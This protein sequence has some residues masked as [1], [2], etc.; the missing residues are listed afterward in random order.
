MPSSLGSPGSVPTLREYDAFI[1]H[2]FE[3]KAELVRPLADRLR[4]YGA[5]IWYDEFELRP[6]DSLVAKIDRGLA[7]SNHGILIISPAFLCKPWPEY[8]R[9]GL[10]ARDIGSGGQILV[11]VWHNVDA[12]RV[13]SFSPTLAQRFALITNTMHVD[14]LA[15]RLLEVVRPDLSEG[16]RRRALFDELVANAT[17][18]WT[19]LGKVQRP[20]EPVHGSLPS[21]LLRRIRLIQ[22]ALYEVL[23][24]SFDET[25]ESFKRDLHPE[26]E[27][28]FWESIAGTYLT[29]VHE[30]GVDS[31]DARGELFHLVLGGYTGQD[32]NRVEI[33][34]LPE[35]QATKI[36]QAFGPKQPQRSTGDAT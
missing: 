33:R 6:G 11:P 19:P 31:A 10:T 1:S 12:D 4:K 25:V 7:E 23:P 18:E 15:L 9:Q 20:E 17:A 2:A 21:E 16:P 28:E 34:H 35:A 8:E 36:R 3:D 14:E 5:R 32:L 29:L 26:R 13:S 27:V 24:V 30:L 22:S